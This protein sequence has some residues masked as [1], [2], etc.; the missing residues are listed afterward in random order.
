MKRTLAT[1]SALAFLLV[2]GS[3]LAEDME[4][5]VKVAD[6]AADTLTLDDGTLFYLGE[7]ASMKGLKP[8]VDVIV[9]YDVQANLKI[10]SK[11][12]VKK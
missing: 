3:A 9:T 11:I 1:L 6:N 4:G 8:G 7:G 12:A 5:K 2:A 10:A